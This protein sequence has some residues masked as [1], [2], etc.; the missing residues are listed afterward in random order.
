M[1]RRYLLRHIRVVSAP[2]LIRYAR[3]WMY[4][5]GLDEVVMVFA[6]Q[7]FSWAL[8]WYFI[9]DLQMPW[10]A[11]RMLYFPTKTRIGIV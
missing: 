6:I 1:P 9:H 3:L 7:A 10:D 8:L 5:S 2:V 4:P 11:F